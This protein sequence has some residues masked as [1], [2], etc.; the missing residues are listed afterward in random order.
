[1]NWDKFAEGFVEQL[2]T[3]LKV[4]AVPTPWPEISDDEVEGLT[5]RYAS[6]EW[7]EQR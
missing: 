5:E 2:A 6:P 4:P 1:V 3:A 7:N